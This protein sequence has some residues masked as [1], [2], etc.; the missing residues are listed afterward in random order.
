MAIK[1]ACV[2]TCPH[3]QTLSSLSLPPALSSFSLSLSRG[4][5]SLSLS[6]FLSRTKTFGPSTRF[7]V[8][9]PTVFCP[10]RSHHRT[11][12]TDHCN[13]LFIFLQ[14][15]A[16]LLL[17]VS[18]SF[19]AFLSPAISA[20]RVSPGSKSQDLGVT[21]PCFGVFFFLFVSSMCVC[22]RACCVYMCFFV[23]YT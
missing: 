8:S 15:P 17:F 7:P 1:S 19:S 3:C 14:E 9:S 10:A 2:P 13:F 12:D 16:L 5:L 21:G 22:V 18:T 23:S 4:L 11:Q 6:L 20:I